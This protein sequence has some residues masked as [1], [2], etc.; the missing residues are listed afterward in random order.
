MFTALTGVVLHCFPIALH[1]LML[2]SALGEDGEQCG[3][4]ESELLIS[5]PR[6]PPSPPGILHAPSPSK[7]L[8]PWDRHT[9]QVLPNCNLDYGISLRLI[10]H[11][12]MHCYPPGS[13]MARPSKLLF[14]VGKRKE[15]CK[16]S[17]SEL[18]I[19]YPRIPESTSDP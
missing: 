15:N 2:I 1:G 16:E 4:I 3:V 14:H 5:D 19:S 17:E 12:R 10:S 13:V 9:G 11:H 6:I 8:P 18:V 7:L